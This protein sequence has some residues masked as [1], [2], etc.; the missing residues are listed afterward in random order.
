M[1]ALALYLAGL[2]LPLFLFALI[3]YVDDRKRGRIA[4]PS[5]SVVRETAGAPLDSSTAVF[6]AQFV[7]AP[8]LAVAELRKELHSLGTPDSTASDEPNSESFERLLAALERT[9]HKRHLLRA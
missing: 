4:V 8:T 5:R 6:E 7:V 1:L 9:R 3:C 2:S